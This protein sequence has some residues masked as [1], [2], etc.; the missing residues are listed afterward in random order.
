[1]AD[2]NLSANMNLPV[3]VVGV[4]PGPDWASDLNACLTL[5]DAHDH[6][7]GSGVQITP[8]G[9][10]INSD[11]TMG[12]TNNLINT[13][14]VRFTDQSVPIAVATD[15]RAVYAVNG[16]LYWNNG[17]L[18]PVQITSGNSIVGTAGSITGLPSGTA[19][20]SYVSG[21][22]KFVWQSASNTPASMD[23]GSFI[24]RNITANS[25]GL[26]VSPPNAMAADYSIVWPSLPGSTSFVSIDSAGNMGAS[27][28]A[29]GGITGSMI[30]S[31]TIAA[32]NLTAT[33]QTF[34]VPTGSILPY[35]GSSAPTGYL[36]CDGSAVSRT[37]YSSLFAVTGTT[38]GVGNGTTTFNLPSTTAPLIT[39]WASYTPVFTGAGTVTTI[40]FFWRR[41]GSSLEVEGTFTTGT[42]TGSTFS[43]TLPSGLTLN[44]AA[45]AGSTLPT[46]VGM[47][48]RNVSAANKLGAVITRID[49]SSSLVYCGGPTGDAGSNGGNAQPGSVIFGV[50]EID[51]FKFSVP[52]LQW[53]ST[54]S[55]IKT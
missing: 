1:M 32:S 19:S 42:P 17:T 53:I 52:I 37:T 24:F 36:L 8:A 2:F 31:G 40:N 33:A 3:P 22:Q 30:A 20:A 16:D 23:G 48:M 10:N 43:I 41:V 39:D 54:T 55:I 35:G 4:A 14:S 34:L 6:S 28:A 9:L 44:T 27:V 26:T 49:S 38:F 18:F 25:K 5:V 45:L 15:L 21:S 13:R 51:T 11:L 46:T 50:G 29:S 7:S 47:Y 12:M